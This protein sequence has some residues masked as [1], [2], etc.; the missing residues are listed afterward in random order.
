MFDLKYDIM[1]YISVII[2]AL[3]FI[4][5][6]DT[7]SQKNLP[8]QRTDTPTP[9]TLTYDMKS[10]THESGDCN[11]EDDEDGD[12]CF[13]VEI[14]F[15]LLT[16]DLPNVDQLNDSIAAFVDIAKNQEDFDNIVAKLKGQHNEEM[17]E[18]YQY[19][20]TSIS[21]APIIFNNGKILTVEHKTY[22]FAGGAHG[23]SGFLYKNIEVATAKTI[24]LDDIIADV[25]AP[26]FVA[27]AEKYFR[28]F[29]SIEEELTLEEAGYFSYGDGFY[30][31]YNYAFTSD[32]LTF[33]YNP[34]EIG[35]YAL[36]APNFTIPYHELTDF[37][38]ADS[39]LVGVGK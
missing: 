4:A 24:H 15:P 38:K 2:V 37:V 20:F 30:V 27:I 7:A 34:Y 18:D 21:E 39:L 14:T 6:G 35:A 19:P 22:M 31:T 32:G 12:P 8:T 29:Q 5:C 13:E 11:Y 26:R 1:N 9:D 36:G 28:E 17:D 16:A 3:A 33:L 23:N 10:Y 25:T